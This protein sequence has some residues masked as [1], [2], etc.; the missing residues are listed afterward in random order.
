MA[1]RWLKERE[2]TLSVPSPIFLWERGRRGC[3]SFFGVLFNFC[4][5]RLS[6][7]HTLT[8]S[9]VLIVTHKYR[10]GALGDLWR[11]G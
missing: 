10:C 3:L 9:L 5:L 11:R 8:L 7:T 4:K 2:A 1:N 6:E